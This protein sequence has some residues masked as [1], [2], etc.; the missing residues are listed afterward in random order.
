MTVDRQ[1]EDLDAEAVAFA[2]ETLRAGGRVLIMGAPRVGKTTLAESIRE[3]FDGDKLITR[4]TDEL[5]GKMP[6]SQA[7]DE[8]VSWIRTP[9]PW[10]IEGVAAVRA[11]RKWLDQFPGL[12]AEVIFWA[13]QPR[14]ERTPKQ[15]SMAKGCATI[16]KPVRDEIASR[17]ATVRC[18]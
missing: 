14:A 2:L 15:E 7:S 18:F 10:V 5:V 16:W 11:V 3:T 1:V 13:T 8:V 6:W 17:G 4:H 9:G 12:P